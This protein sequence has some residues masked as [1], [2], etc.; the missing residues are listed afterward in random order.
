MHTSLRTA[1]DT[2]VERESSDDPFNWP[3]VGPHFN[4]A[5]DWF[6]AFARGCDE[7][8]LVIVAESGEARS[9]S[10]ADLVDGSDRVGAFLSARGVRQGDAV[11]LMLGNQV[12]LWMT[13]LALI[14]I[15]AV[16]I[17]TTSAVTPVELRDRI[18]RGNASAIVCNPEDV[19]RVRDV[20]SPQVITSEELREAEELPATPLPHPGNSSD[21][22]LLLYFTS[23]TTSRPKLVE[24]THT[25]YPVGHLTT[26]YWLGLRPGDV[27]LN[28][29]APGWAK[30]AYSMFFA[31]WLA[32]ATVVAFNY[33]R[34]D[35]PSLLRV[36]AEHHITT[37][38]APPTVWRMLI[39]ADLSGGPG[40]LRELMSAGEPL[41]AEV[42]QQ[43]RAAWGLTI[44][45]G[46]GQTETTLLVGN[47]S[48]LTVKPGSMGRPLIPGAIVLVDPA[49]GQP[50]PTEGE[51]CVDLSTS[52]VNIMT[53][54]QGD[55]VRNAEAM[56]GGFYHT[57][58][59]ACM[60]SE[61]Y[62]TFIGRDDDVFKSSDY[63]ISPFELESVLVEHPA[64]LEAAVVPSPDPV[65]LAVPKAYVAI[66]PGHVPDQATADSI[67]RHARQHLPPYLRVRKLEFVEL[68]K[69]TSGKI[70]R[71]E[72]RSRE[73]DAPAGAAEFVDG[74]A[75]ARSR[76]IDEVAP[77]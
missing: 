54:Y 66:A 40:A 15:G 14:K 55:E 9:Y 77:A 70:R 17:P 50:H 53:G 33:E 18:E 67:F 47:T 27:H 30:H 61:G 62:I 71:T 51:V 12:E 16:I 4:W 39:K 73:A 6:D 20:G 7:T 25:S 23:G 63:K 26:M 49:T 52:P 13:M 68:P 59:L 21:D 58:D 41:N 22:R 46:Y 29:S 8:G 32:Q 11:I 74:S 28:I 76:P 3:D 31:P 60:D 34:F 45:D 19:A 72:L 5:H 24:H 43:V 1:R 65:R 36:L 44:R 56:A 69:T 37:F 2:L 35:A 57:G 10:F 64:V 75:G 48:G 42:I 38:C